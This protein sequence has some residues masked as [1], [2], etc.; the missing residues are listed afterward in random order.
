MDERRR[1]SLVAGSFGP[2]H[3]TAAQLLAGG[4]VIPGAIARTI[5]SR[6]S[7]A[8]SF[9]PRAASAIAR[10]A[11][12]VIGRIGGDARLELTPVVGGAGHLRQLERGLDALDGGELAL[13]R[14][15]QRDRLLGAGGVAADEVGAGEPGERRRV[16]LVLAQHAAKISAAVCRSPA[17]SAASASFRTA[18]MS[19][20]ASSP[21]TRSTNARTGSPAALP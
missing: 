8:A 20:S 19:A 6:W 1:P 14:R 21:R 9:S 16:L 5:S 2:G 10:S 17:S 3:R 15:H 11:R 4:L 7:R 18:A 13:V 12:L